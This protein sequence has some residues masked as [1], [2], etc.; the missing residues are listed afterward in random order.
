MMK[1]TLLTKILAAK[2]NTVS[3]MLLFLVGNLLTISHEAPID[4]EDNNEYVLHV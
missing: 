4:D 1:N 2:T 3:S